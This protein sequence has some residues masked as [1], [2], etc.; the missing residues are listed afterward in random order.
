MKQ[1]N[2]STQF[3]AKTTFGGALLKAG[4][5][6][7]GARPLDSKFPIHLVLKAER[8]TMRLPKHYA[9]VNHIVHQTMRKH[10]VRLYEYANCGNHLHHLIK[11]PRRRTWSAFIRELTGRLAQVT[12]VRWMHRP[13]T[14]L[15]KGWKKAFRA[16]KEYVRL[17]RVEVERGLTRRAA[18]SWIEANVNA[19]ADGSARQ[20]RPQ[21][22]FV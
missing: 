12:G 2:L 7:K 8:S 10:G 11:L 16:V 14:R 6:P 5:N 20:A 17:N 15:I 1:L 22:A 3:I 18:R 9:R 19:S 13:F 4:T 21:A